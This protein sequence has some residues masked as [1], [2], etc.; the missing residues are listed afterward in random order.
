[1][2]EGQS[3]RLVLV[4]SII[5]VFMA[6]LDTSI[7]NVAIPK[8]MAVFSVDAKEIQWVITSYT[9]VVGT[10]IPV[11]GFVTER[12]GFKKIFIF[13]LTVFTIGSLLCGLA[14]N[15]E[16]MIIFRIIQ[17]I[18]GGAL[19]P[20]SQAMLFRLF[21]REK[22][23]QVMG[24]F[25]IS[26]MFAPA[27]GPT[28]SGYFIEYFD[29]RLIFFINVPIGIVATIIAMISFKELD[30]QVESKF[31]VSGFITS[32]V[33]FSTLLYGIGLVPEKGWSDDEVVFFIGIGIV[34]LLAFVLIEW[35]KESP[36]LDL[37]ILKNP[38]FT[39]AQVITSLTSVV[40]FVPLFLFPIF[41]ENIAGLSALQTGLLLL[42]QALIT[43]LMMPV[44]GMLFDR[45]GARWLAVIG[46]G[47]TAYSLHLTT[48]LDVNTSFSTI[49][50]W[51]IL[52]GIGISL[53]MMP[54]STAGMNAVPNHLVAQATALSN[55][56]RQVA[57]S[58]GIAWATL[59]WTNRQIFHTANY[60]DQYNMFSDFSQGIVQQMQNVYMGMGQSF[61]EARS[62]ALGYITGQIQIQ[63]T[64]QAMG[65]VFYIS[66][67][68]ALFALFISFFIGKK[69]E[70]KKEEVAK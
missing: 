26:I 46:M 14:W 65:D 61:A 16:S 67:W 30:H 8:M 39:I 3:R 53:V 59:L 49:I 45:I 37:R 43:G 12:F 17:A 44:A 28:L 40:L 1:L 48:Q 5:A 41:L 42:P 19:M 57:A 54:I 35:F 31:D 27:I 9:L 58:F 34:S 24:L 20:V 4:V 29:W 68:L 51:L 32:T 7:V 10:I 13:S 11:T 18:G 36:M 2:P 63:S 25:G 70:P 60:S 69:E 64:V 23:G 52:R 56:I 6:I 55:T 15:N 66:M 38:V 50:F 33:G 47:I 22:R 21:P 62:S